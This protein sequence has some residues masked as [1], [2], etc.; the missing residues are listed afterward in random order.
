VGSLVC[1]RFG[2]EDEFR[3]IERLRKWR[4][5]PLPVILKGEGK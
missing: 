4:K 1:R 3:E 2:G 5:V